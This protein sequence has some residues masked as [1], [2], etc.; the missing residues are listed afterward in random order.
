[1]ALQIEQNNQNIIIF[2][3]GMIGTVTVS[4]ILKNYHLEH[5]VLFYVDN[6]PNKWGKSV[7]SGENEYQIFPVDKLKEIEGKDIVIFL[8]TSRF[9]NSLSQLENL[10]NIQD[11]LCYMIPMMCISNFQPSEKEII[12]KDSR[13]PLIPKVIHYMWLGIKEIPRPLQLCIDSWKKY[14]PD[15]EIR[16]WNES[17]YDIEKNVYMKQAY[18]RKMY[19]FVP[20]YAR[21]DILYT[22][23]G[24]YLDTDVELVKNLDDLLYQEAFCSV[25]KWQTIN[26]GGGS[27]SVKNNEAIGKLLKA[28]KNLQFVDQYGNQDKNT[29]G[30]YDTLALQKY[31]YKIC[32]GPQKILNL[33]IYSYDVFHPYDYMSGRTDLSANTYGIHHFN[34]GWLDEKMKEENKKSSDEFERIY[35]LASDTS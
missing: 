8:T 2:G 1:M 30:Y 4:S 3:A 20:D 27:G 14:C 23:G 11:M 29:C 17:N 22:Y 15:Y 31:G 16:C 5:R 12:R 25:E 18:E 6:D 28:R 26:F 32:G 19:G 33:N 34:G 7:L 10:E 9:S 35:K 13:E 21:L 24:I